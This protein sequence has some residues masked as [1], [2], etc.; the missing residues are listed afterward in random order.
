VGLG[1]AS[2]AKH[3]ICARFL[4]KSRLGNAI[5]STRPLCARL[6]NK[7]IFDIILKKT[8]FFEAASFRKT[9]SKRKRRLGA[10]TAPLTKI[11]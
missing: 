2:P 5:F 3:H 6:T 10:G 9:K 8:I 1:D 4:D 11:K 7:K